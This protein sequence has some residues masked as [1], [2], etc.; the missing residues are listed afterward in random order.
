MNREDYLKSH[1]DFI[2]TSLT[3][4]K[5]MIV[6][7]FTILIYYCVTH[8][9]DEVEYIWSRKWT[10]GKAIYLITRYFWTVYFT[11]LIINNINYGWNEFTLYDSHLI[12]TQA[13]VIYTTF[14]I[15]SSPIFDGIAIIL[16][17]IILQMRV[18]AVYGRNKR[19][20]A[21]LV[22]MTLSSVVVCALQ[23]TKKVYIHSKLECKD[24]VAACLASFGLGREKGHFS[25]VTAYYW[26]YLTYPIAAVSWL[27]VSTV[28]RAEPTLDGRNPDVMAT[29]ARDSI[30][31]FAVIFTLGLIA[32]IL[33]FITEINLPETSNAFHFIAHLL[34]TYRIV[35]IT[36]M[37][38]LAP[39]MLISIRL[40]VYR[41][42]APIEMLTWEAA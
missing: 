17:E 3:M 8:L 26:S 33:S 5:S 35:V 41:L 30:T 25:D 18:Y 6:S 28:E 14:Y 9:D 39:R 24:G 16:A 20:L 15:Y 1:D 12:A 36:T 11:Y 23:P 37:S 10:K 40:E 13:D 4:S 34:N 32:T 29:I 2:A 22:C 19:V 42:D 38:I 31:Y 7:S 21:A 27:V